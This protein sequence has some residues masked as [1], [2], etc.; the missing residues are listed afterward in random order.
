MKDEGWRVMGAVAVGQSHVRHGTPC[1]DA[2][3]FCKRRRGSIVS[4][5]LADGAGSRKLSHLGAR[6]VTLGVSR[7]AANHF[8]SLWKLPEAE[9][10]T[11]LIACAQRNLKKLTAQHVGTKAED[12][13][14][15]LM[16]VACNADRVIAANLGDGVVARRDTNGSWSALLPP[17]RGEHANETYFLTSPD[18]KRHLRVAKCEKADTAYLI[19]TDGAADSLYERSTGRIAPAAESFV[20]WMQTHPRKAAQQALQETLSTTLT[21]RTHD[22]CGVGVVKNITTRISTNENRPH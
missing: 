11:R 9:V 8:H 20:G 22:D 4:M 3:E 5:A 13:A 10:S 21:A 6:A 17:Q 2:F 15:T 7:Y 16:L 19:M 1:Q 14:C 18:I 12:F